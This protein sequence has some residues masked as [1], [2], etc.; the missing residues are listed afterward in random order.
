MATTADRRKQAP[1][2]WKREQKAS[3]P[4]RTAGQYR[5]KASC[6]WRPAAK[7]RSPK[8]P[9]FN[10]TPH[11]KSATNLAMYMAGRDTGRLSSQ[12]RL[13][14]S[15]SPPMASVAK[16]RL[17]MGRRELRKMENTIQFE[18]TK[19]PDRSMTPCQAPKMASG[20]Q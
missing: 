19:N 17:Q 9:K 15:C 14:D 18:N 2:R 10:P 5:R 12:I 11:G 20:P 13:R 7:Q 6:P 4:A 3:E 16:L 8:P 1:I